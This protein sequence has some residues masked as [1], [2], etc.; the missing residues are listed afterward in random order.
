MPGHDRLDHVPADL[1]VFVER[2]FGS[3]NNFYR[4]RPKGTGKEWEARGLESAGREGGG[5][6]TGSTAGRVLR[7]GWVELRLFDLLRNVFGSVAPRWGTAFK[8]RPKV[9]HS[10]RLDPRAKILVNFFQ[11]E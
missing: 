7:W 9:V 2:F 8:S 10:N 5:V 4:I 11:N 6:A 1:Y 3:K